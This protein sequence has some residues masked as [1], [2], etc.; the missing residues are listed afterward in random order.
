MSITADQPVSQKGIAAPA[1]VRPE[2]LLAL[3]AILAGGALAVSLLGYLETGNRLDRME[4]DLETLVVS[5][6]PE[7]YRIH[8]AREATARF[9]NAELS[10]VESFGSRDELLTNALGLVDPQ[11]NGLIAE[12][13]VFRGASINHLARHT[14][15]QVHGFDSFEGLPEKWGEGF[16]AGKF[17]IDGLPKVRD[18]VVLHKGWFDEVLPGFRDQHPEP[19]DFL[20][21]DADLYSSTATVLEMLGD[22][23]RPGTV[24]VFDEF[25]G[26]PGWEHGEFLAFREFVD[27][28]DA[29]FEY[30]GWVPGDQQVAVRIKSLGA[31]SR[32]D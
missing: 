9:A 25:M 3:A 12:F 30:V 6:S 24:I 15:R 7:Y 18:N 13:G 31:S 27:R 22:R 4:Y 10:G 1:R 21:M 19:V 26:Y 5:R 8:V 17:K 16:E 20:H 28:H 29:E 2:F 11:G 14:E 32:A 23:I